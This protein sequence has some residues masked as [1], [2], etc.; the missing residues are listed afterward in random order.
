MRRDI[1]ALCD[2][3]VGG[4]AGTAAM[5][6]LMLAGQESG[7]MPRQPPEDVTEAAL[8]AAGMAPRSEAALD[9]V[10]VLAHFGFG[11]ACGAVFGLLHRRLGLPIPAAVH[12]TIFGGL[13][14]AAMYE[15]GIPALGILPPPERDRTG[16]SAVMVPAHLLYGAVLGAVVGDSKTDG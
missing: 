4:I 13:V 3:A 11:A 15:V 16:R 2:G 7:L 1:Q 9:A 14:W 10:T 8:D 5:S 6:V 12:G